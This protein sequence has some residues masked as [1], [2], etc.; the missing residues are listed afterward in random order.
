M[1][2]KRMHALFCTDGI[3]PHAVGGMQR[4]S[5]L[6]IKE[7]AKTGE[8]DLS[9]IHPHDKT[10]FDDSRIKE[11]PLNF[12]YSGGN[13]IRK[14]MEYSELVLQKI[15]EINPD[16]IYSQ[17]LSVVKGLDE[18]KDK[19]IINPHGLEPFQAISFMDKLKSTPLRTVERFQFKRA[20]KVIS[21]GG[22]L[23]DILRREMPG[24]NGRI[25]VIPN[26]VNPGP[27]PER[28]F[29]KTKLQLLFVG[30]FAFNK[31]INILMDAVAQLNNEGYANRLEFNLV[32]KGPLFESYKKK[33]A[34]DNVNF[35][36]FADDDKLVQLY[37]ENDLFVF[38]TRFEGMPTVV[39]EAMA[40]GMPVIVSDTGA[41]A[42][43]VDSSNGYLIETNSVRALKWAIQSFYQ[44]TEDERRNM[45]LNSYKK[46]TAS[47]TWPEIARQHLRLFSSVAKT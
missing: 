15:K 12:N 21:L 37:H 45:S 42:E 41:T 25:A 18:I 31:G 22:K 6:L 17:G 27:M 38:P 36:G 35:L 23:T 14:C 24:A 20:A 13:Y 2:M 3:F 40:A 1:N 4:H 26:A 19:V 7:L 32:G 43:L 47:F 28:S 10:V 44:L 34:F 5:L 29:N 11:Y 8:I 30:R 46:V 39:L 16:V 33:Y 9:V